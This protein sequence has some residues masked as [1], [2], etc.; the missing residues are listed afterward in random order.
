MGSLSAGHTG[1]RGQGREKQMMVSLQ[2]KHS[3]E[4]LD[5]LQLL[6]FLR[7]NLMPCRAG[8]HQDLLVVD[9]GTVISNKQ[10]TGMHLC[11]IIAM[12]WCLPLRYHTVVQFAELKVLAVCLL[13]C[14][15]QT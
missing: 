3:E 1:N 11:L 15:E 9:Q 7:S 4:S 14:S 5:C 2:L 12:H 8:Q 10:F 13:K 6:G